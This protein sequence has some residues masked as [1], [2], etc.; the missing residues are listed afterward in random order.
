LPAVLRAAG[1][2]VKTILSGSPNLHAETVFTGSAKFSEALAENPVEMPVERIEKRPNEAV[3]VRFA[4]T[5]VR[6]DNAHSIKQLENCARIPLSR[7]N[8]AISVKDVSTRPTA[9]SSRTSRAREARSPKLLAVLTAAEMGR[10]TKD[11]TSLGAGTVLAEN[12]LEGRDDLPERGPR[13]DRGEDRW[14]QISAFSRVPLEAFPGRRESRSIPG[15][16][17]SPQPLDLIP[18][19]RRVDLEESRSDLL[20]LPK[21]VDPDDD[22]PP[23]LDLL[24]SEVGRLFDLAGLE[25]RL[26]RGDRPPSFVDLS[27]QSPSPRRDL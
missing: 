15:V 21:G 7:P 11:G 18:L 2:A 9:S 19:E 27:D 12:S 8:P 3:L 26:D 25:S 22:P 6:K 24:L 16:P 14:H 1:E 23:C 4:P 17:E 5:V 10:A 20:L 13:L